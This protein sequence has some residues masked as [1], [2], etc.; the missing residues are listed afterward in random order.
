MFTIQHNG[1]V[2]N[3]ELTEIDVNEIP[4]DSIGDFFRNPRAK[5]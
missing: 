4:F 3:N 5:K 1:E 2:T